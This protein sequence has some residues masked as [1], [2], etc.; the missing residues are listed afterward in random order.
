MASHK[1][2]K[3]FAAAPVSG[4]LSIQGMSTPA[5]RMGAQAH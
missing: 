2:D 1:P 5:L 3:V 4:Y